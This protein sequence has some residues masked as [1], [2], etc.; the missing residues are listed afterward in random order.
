MKEEKQQHKL[1][2]ALFWCTGASIAMFL[3]SHAI[4]LLVKRSG[5]PYPASVAIVETIAYF[6]ALLTSVVAVPVGLVSLCA[7]RQLRTSKR[8]PLFAFLAGLIFLLTFF[9]VPTVRSFYIRA[10]TPEPWMTTE[11]RE[12]QESQQEN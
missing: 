11:N 1:S 3:A 7:P 8:Y 5:G 12:T 10:Q 4:T 6:V 9:I 2:R